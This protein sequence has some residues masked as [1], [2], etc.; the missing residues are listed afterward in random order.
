[1]ATECVVVADSASLL[2]T[3]LNHAIAITVRLKLPFRFAQMVIT[4]LVLSVYKA[5]VVL[6]N[7]VERLAELI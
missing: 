1:M 3:A 7:F 2:F 5:Q 4:V 6:P